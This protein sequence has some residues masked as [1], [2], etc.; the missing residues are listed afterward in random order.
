[1]AFSTVNSGTNSDKVTILGNGNVGIGSISPGYKLVV[2]GEIVNQTN[3]NSTGDPGLLITSGHRLGFDQSGVRSWN[4]KATGGNLAFNSGDGAGNY[5]FIGNNVGIGTTAPA[6]T[7]D[8]NGS[9]RSYNGPSYEVVKHGTFNLNDGTAGNFNHFITIGTTNVYATSVELTL[10][11][12]NIGHSVIKYT[13]VTNYDDLNDP[14]KRIILPLYSTNPRFEGAG[15]TYGGAVHEL[16][17]WSDGSGTMF[18]RLVIKT[19]GSGEVPNWYWTAKLKNCDI[20]ATPNSTGNDTT[21][22]S[23]YRDTQ[24]TQRNGNVGIGTTSPGS[25]LET[26][27]GTPVISINGTTLGG[28][29]GIE[30]KHSGENLGHIKFNASSG[31][32]AFSVGKAAFGSFMTFTSDTTERM[33]ISSTGNIGIG[34]T[35]P[36]ESLTIGQNTAGNG[37]AYSLAILRNGTSASPGSWSSTPAIRIDDVSGDGPSSFTGGQAL[38]QINVGRI[39]D[40]DTNSNNAALINCVNDNGSAFMVTAKRR[41]GIQQTAPAYELDVSGTIRATGDVIAYSDARVKENINTITDALTKVISLRGVSYTRKDTDDKSE[42]V[43]VIAQEVL[44]VLPQVVSQDDK[45]QY[46]VAYG[47][48][49]GVLIEAIKEQQKQIDELKYLLQTQNK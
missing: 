19:R 42:K 47:N 29:R 7:L 40:S 37:T 20:T 6:Y 9:Q 22:Y 30:F 14:A 48:M 49:V 2:N 38:L 13:I 5:T 21:N 15:G 17:M 31:Q 26:Y 39:A 1:M 18:L 23:I 24:I 25:I 33:R 4:I 45:G 35:A 16:Q 32:L 11:E 10:S 8:I 46:S 12:V 27:A 43:G 34:T 28:D 41:V 44:E 36:G 3:L